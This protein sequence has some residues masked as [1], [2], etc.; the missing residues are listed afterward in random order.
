MMCIVLVEGDLACA[1]LFACA[2]CSSSC[3][4]PLSLLVA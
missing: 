1:V 3:C 2:R 4:R